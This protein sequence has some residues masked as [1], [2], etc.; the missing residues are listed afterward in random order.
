MRSARLL[1]LLL[2]LA[3]V[4]TCAGAARSDTTAPTG[5]HGFLLRADEPQTT[6]FPRTPSF[7]WNPIPGATHYE[8][9]L[10]L[11]TTFRDNAVI[12]DDGSALTPVEAP[13]LTLPWITGS[14]YALY[15]RVRAFTADGATA[16]STSFGFDMAPSAP[17]T[18]LQSYPGLIR[19]T[20]VEGAAGYQVWL[21]DAKKIEST[22]TNSI[23]E[24]EYY[25]FHQTPNWTGSIRWRVRAMRDDLNGGGLNGIPAVTYGAWSP[26]YTS[27]NPPITGG[28]IKLVG[29]VS[30]VF[31]NGSAGSPAHKVMP[32]F[33]WT[34]NQAI[35]GTPVELYRVYVFTDK[36]CLNRVFTGAVI[37]SPAYSPRPMGPLA[38]P[39]SSAG[40][41]AARSTYLADGSEPPA[42]TYD[43]QSVTTSESAAP[44]SPT[45]TVPGALGATTGGS[46]TTTTAP[47]TSGT[48]P[49]ATTPG[50]LT[51][52]GNLGAP[53][54]L[55]DTNWPSSGYYWT[56]V[57]VAAVSAPT[58]STTVGS[59]GAVAA[60]TTL[61]VTTGSGF[62]TG[63]TITIG[64]GPNAETAVITAVNG[65]VLTLAGGLKFGHGAGEA[66]T[67]S[68]GSLTYQD[69]EL[70]QDVCAAG[71][72]MRFGKASEPSLT[73]SG[74]LFATGL[75][76]DGR[77]TSA[78]HT[79]SFY[80]QPLVSW[81]P[82]L[83]A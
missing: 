3:G 14:P 50:T 32:A 20:P 69:L 40:I 64:T 17:P 36:Q 80:G 68:G 57:A 76:S 42:L 33:L 46:T 23:D 62:T 74:Q 34:G 44:A 78:L 43:G 73:S 4:A 67:R 5:L 11:S 31:S 75:S 58:F 1:V 6:T 18:P 54:D 7:A 15:A 55:W 39:S 56:V 52:S 9:Q 81:T 59:A 29:T 63:D 51:V 60:A 83:G 82:A 30:D 47:P 16:W 22:T 8:F 25:T 49:G 66:V 24:R 13:G 21:I 35:D 61:A 10:S 26:I 71:R 79:T 12:Y 48:S 70:P 77:L 2:I 19:W 41:A 72:V 65:N 28:A 53:I 38:L 27:T 45:T 37:G